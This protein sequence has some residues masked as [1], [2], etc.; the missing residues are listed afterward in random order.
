MLMIPPVHKFIAEKVTIESICTYVI[1]SLFTLA[2]CFVPGES[3]GQWTKNNAMTTGLFMLKV[4]N[5]TA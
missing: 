1:S 5:G 2:I 4:A 3:R